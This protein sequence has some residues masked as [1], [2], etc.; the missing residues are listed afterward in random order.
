MN[1]FGLMTLIQYQDISRELAINVCFPWEL[2]PGKIIYL[3]YNK[4]WQRSWN[5]MSRLLPLQ[6]RGGFKV[7]LSI[8]S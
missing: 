8:R 1:Q 5:P 4:N 6:E 2:S 3:V 7:E